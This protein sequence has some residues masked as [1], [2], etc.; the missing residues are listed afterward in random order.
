MPNQANTQ[1]WDSDVRINVLEGEGVAAEILYPNTIPPFFPSLG[2]FISLP[3]TQDEYDHR[4]AG[5]QAHNRWQSDFC[6]QTPGRRV[7]LAQILLNDL[8]DA[9]AEV[10][11]AKENEFGGILI[12]AVP[13]NHPSV[14]GI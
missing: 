8:D 1:I 7:G 14:P 13:P 10:R 5:L 9:L 11:W 2:L 3:K 12:P 6:S 4:W